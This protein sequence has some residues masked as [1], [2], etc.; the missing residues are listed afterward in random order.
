[1]PFPTAGSQRCKSRCRRWFPDTDPAN[2]WETQL[3]ACFFGTQPSV[4]GV[5][6][7]K[8]S[9]KSPKP[10]WFLF[11]LQIRHRLVFWMVKLCH[12]NFHGWL[13]R[14]GKWIE[15]SAFRTFS[16][17]C[18]KSLKWPPHLSEGFCPTISQPQDYMSSHGKTSREIGGCPKPWQQVDTVQETN[19]LER[20][21]VSSVSEAIWST[22]Q[23]LQCSNKISRALE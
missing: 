5:F 15:P 12:L 20:P 1:M 13:R 19:G 3:G 14:H 7:F 8:Q 10:G 17:T 23:Q 18:M 6:Y 21:S 2:I 16:T 11:S 9:L 4:S 22:T